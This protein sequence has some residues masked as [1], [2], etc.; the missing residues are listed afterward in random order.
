MSEQRL[1]AHIPAD[2]LE[3]TLKAY[4]ALF[5]KQKIKDYSFVVEESAEICTLTRVLSW[6]EIKAQRLQQRKR[7]KFLALH[8]I[9][10]SKLIAVNSYRIEVN[11]FVPTP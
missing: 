5:K 9:D 6:R 4:R 10:E 7:S 8:G 2:R 1:T 3:K 11:Y